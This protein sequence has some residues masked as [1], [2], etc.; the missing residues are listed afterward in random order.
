[1]TEELTPQQVLTAAKQLRPAMGL[2]MN[3]AGTE[4][5]SE[6]PQD[7][8]SDFRIY[9]QSLSHYNAGVL[10]GAWLDVEDLDLEEIHEAIRAFLAYIDKL[11]LERE[12]DLGPIEEYEVADV[13]LPFKFTS[14]EELVSLKE[15]CKSE[16]GP[17]LL[18][19]AQDCG[20]DTDNG[21][22][23]IQDRIMWRVKNSVP[24]CMSDARED[25]AW[26]QLGEQGCPERF[27]SWIDLDHAFQELIDGFSYYYDTGSENG[28]VV[29]SN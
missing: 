19:A 29:F 6:F 27:R 8:N 26:E 14:F 9:I 13:E 28:L 4:L 5:E 11:E 17:F 7:R 24:G 3:L 23:H 1:M 22:E 16:D 25:W 2:C 20:I 10:V 18:K 15:I 21:L 12:S